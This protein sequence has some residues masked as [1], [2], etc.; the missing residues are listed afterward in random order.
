MLEKVKGFFRKAGAKIV[1]LSVATT[2]LIG[3]AFAATPTPPAGITE[4]QVGTFMTSV[5]DT[6]SVA[7]IVKYLALIVSFAVVYAFAWWVIRK[8]IRGG[9]AA[10]KRGKIRV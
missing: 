1:A 9:V 8:V 7:D 2:A 10:V 6:F 3:S 4:E 5:T